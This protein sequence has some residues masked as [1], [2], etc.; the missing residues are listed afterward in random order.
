MENVYE[1]KKRKCLDYI[2]PKGEKIDELKKD[3]YSSVII[4]I[5]IFYDEKIDFFLKYVENIPEEIFVFITVAKEQTREYIREYLKNTD[6]K[7]KVVIKENQGRDIS[8]LL[9]TAR[10]E[11]LKYKYVC[12]LHD[13]KEKCDEKKTDIDQWSYCLWENSIGSK[14]FINN[15]IYTFEKNSI[16][17]LLVPPSPITENL[18]YGYSNSW[19]SDFGLVKNLSKQMGLKCDLDKAFP[20]IALG[21]VFWARV[22]ALRSLFQRDW[23]YVDFDPEPLAND[24]TLSHAIERILP[25]VVQDSGYETGWVM[26]D[27]YAA[28]Q[29]EY[30]AD[31]LGML[32]NLLENM[33]KIRYIS[34]ARK[35]YD[36]AVMLPQFCKAF[37]KIY[38]YG[39]GENG[40]RCF[41]LM[42]ALGIN[43]KAFIVTY[44][45]KGKRNFCGMA[46]HSVD[47][48]KLDD[49]C[50]IVIAVSRALV[51]EIQNLL[52]S[53]NFLG[54]N[55][56]IFE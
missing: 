41:S 37:N 32:F 8:S 54:E 13:K 22:D 14:I 40:K 47:E 28:K 39:A 34:K 25:F 49:S 50:G 26:T 45:E 27:Q 42:I 7:Y 44:L 46:V 3:I 56:F 4:V 15:I 21:T 43:P 9:V 52:F 29:F 11:I 17:G 5:H 1:I 35:L 16:I 53:K 18:E 23:K 6:R 2:L 51:E 38:I 33:Q 24:G 30:Q 10:T 55:I 31:V 12:F 20:P 19:G 48:I 36:M